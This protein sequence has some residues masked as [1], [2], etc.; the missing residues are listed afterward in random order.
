MTNFSNQPK[1]SNTKKDFT[2][3]I[4]LILKQKKQDRILKQK[5][6]KIKQYEQLFYRY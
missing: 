6:P 1:K 4:E 3:L 2:S 5:N